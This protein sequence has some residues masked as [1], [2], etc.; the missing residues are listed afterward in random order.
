MIFEAQNRQYSLNFVLSLASL[1]AYILV[2]NEPKPTV[3][4]PSSFLH[5]HHKMTLFR[6]THPT[7]RRHIEIVPY[8]AIEIILI[9]FKVTKHGLDFCSEQKIYMWI[10]DWITK[11]KRYQV[12]NLKGNFEKF[13][14]EAHVVQVMSVIF[15][16]KNETIVKSFISDKQK[17]NLKKFFEILN[18]KPSTQNSSFFRSIFLIKLLNYLVISITF[19]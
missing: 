2:E 4:P 3:R 16:Q 15:S 12:L 7:V 11:K 18:F 17:K 9:H 5:C 1:N 10:H 6:L 19:F 14:Q 13:T 8:Q